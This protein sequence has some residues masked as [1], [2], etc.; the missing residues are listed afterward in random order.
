M[1]GKRRRREGKGRGREGGERDL[2]PP[3][4]NPGAATV[5]RSILPPQRGEGATLLSSYT[6]AVCDSVQEP[7]R[8]LNCL[9]TDFLVL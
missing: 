6:A 1:E 5:F 3:E 2:A 4:K 9:S 8:S 7:W